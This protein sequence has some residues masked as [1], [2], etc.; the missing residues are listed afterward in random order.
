MIIVQIWLILR[1][2]YTIDIS[3]GT[4]FT[5]LHN[6]LELSKLCV[7]W[8]LKMLTDKYYKMCIG[9]GKAFL[10]SKPWMWNLATAPEWFNLIHVTLWRSNILL[11]SFRDFS[12]SN[13]FFSKNLIRKKCTLHK[14]FFQMSILSS[15]KPRECSSIYNE[16]IVKTH[17]WED[18]P[19]LRG[20]GRW[21]TKINI[22]F[23]VG[24]DILKTFH[25]TIFSKKKKT[26]Q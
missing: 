18:K 9:F 1:K 5:N 4:I 26:I 25:L 12:K 6:N 11:H 17:L 7:Y 14:I 21:A 23:L 22:T 15:S 3:H 19:V 24:N 8:V 20:R 13:A 16:K 10:S 2:D